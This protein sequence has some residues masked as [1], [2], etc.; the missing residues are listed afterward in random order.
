MVNRPVRITCPN[1]EIPAKTGKKIII[2]FR[3]FFYAFL[4]KTYY[5]LVFMAKSRVHKGD[6]SNLSTG[7]F[8]VLPVRLSL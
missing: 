1:G 8:P 5:T 3:V 7:E 2:F 6:F 4:Q